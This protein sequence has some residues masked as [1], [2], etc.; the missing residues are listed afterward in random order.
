MICMYEYDLWPKA[1]KIIG[2]KQGISK[3]EKGNKKKG[4]R[5]LDIVSFKRKE[6]RNF[7]SK[8]YNDNGKFRGGKL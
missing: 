2:S 7:I 8:I 3:Q 5:R 4:V 6:I 1:V